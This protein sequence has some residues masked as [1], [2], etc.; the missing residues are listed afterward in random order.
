MPPAPSAP[1]L[2]QSNPCM[3]VSTLNVLSAVNA[4]IALSYLRRFA[5]S[6]SSV[7]YSVRP[8]ATAYPL[9]RRSALRGHRSNAS[10]ARAAAGHTSAH[11][12]Q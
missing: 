12:V 7:S 3:T 9:W 6:A 11:T 1:P 8:N 10:T 4:P 5:G 2:P